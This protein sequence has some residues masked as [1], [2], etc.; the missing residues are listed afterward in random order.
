M[1][2]TTIALS[3]LAAATFLTF[4]A[5]AAGPVITEFPVAADSA[6]N[7][8]A[9]GPD[10]AFWFTENAG[11]KIGR[12]TVSGSLSEFTLPTAGSANEGITAGPDG[13]LWFVEF[14]N[15]RIGRITTTGTV[16]EFTIPTANSRPLKIVTGPDGGLWFTQRSSNQIGRIDPSTHVFSEFP[17]PTPSSTPARI[18]NG[19]DGALWF[20]EGNADKIGRITTSGTITE[21]PIPTTNSGLGPIASGPD[22][23]LWFIEQRANKVGRITTSGTVTEF[24]IPT[25][26]TQPESINVGSDGALWFT[27][28]NVNQ[29]AR[30]TTK[31]VIAEFAASAGSH[32]SFIFMGP[33]GNIW[34]SEFGTSKIGRAVPAPSTSLLVSAVLPSSRSITV[35]GTATAFATMINA[36]TSAA[37]SCTIVPTTSV[38]ASFTFQTT[39]PATNALT[40]TANA[41]V[42]IPAGG[43]QSFVIAF[44]ANAAFPPTDVA[45]GFDCAGVEAAP[46][47]SGLNTLLL[48]GSASPVPDI[49]ALAASG[50][51]GIVDIPG[52]TGTGVFAVATVNVG[53]SGAITA[54]ADTGAAVLPLT[55]N[56]CQ[57]NPTTGVCTTAIGPSVATTINAGQTPTFGIFVTGNGNVSFS[58]ALNRIFVRFKDS[59]GLTRGSTSVAVRTQ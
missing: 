43:M 33:D 9:L 56:L 42:A 35:G 55:V 16:T 58:P 6:P 4:S 8:M 59:N 48:S 2:I 28:S 19:P 13:A 44:T 18:V 21:F 17:I 26:G 3:A 30:I 20:T 15:N 11:N 49:V 22:G 25:A 23:A 37:P 51:P 41:A 27:E 36:D 50:D 39:N 53:A 38:P 45:L 29:I 14:G 5:H 47:N 32:P 52:A 1:R 12:F 46:I 31:G 7:D 10:G 54:S 57:T 40:G 34:F 24:P